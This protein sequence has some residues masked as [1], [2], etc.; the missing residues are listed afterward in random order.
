MFCAIFCVQTDLLAQSKPP[1]KLKTEQTGL[2]RR[3]YSEKERKRKSKGNVKRK[4]KG[5]QKAYYKKK[6]NQTQY[7]GNIWIDPKPK[8]FTAIK[9][10]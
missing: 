5:L 1:T 7:P 8:D 3:K 4:N 6:S 10:R 9:E 2:K